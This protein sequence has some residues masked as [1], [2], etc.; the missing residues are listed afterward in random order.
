MLG[1]QPR[2]Q[3][4]V[5]TGKRFAVAIAFAQII[6]RQRL[7]Q[8]LRS[9]LHQLVR[10]LSKSNVRDRRI[11]LAFGRG[12][13]RRKLK[14]V[15]QQQRLIDF[16]QIVVFRRHP[17]NRDT[18]NARTLHLFRQR[19]HRRS[20][21][22]RQQRPAKQS[23]LLPGHHREGAFPQPPNIVQRLFRSSPAAILLL[24]HIGNLSVNLGPVRHDRSSAPQPAR[25]PA[26]CG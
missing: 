21:E 11:E 26:G 5:R 3:P 8:Q 22:Q 25:R 12:G 19:Q 15:V 4:G 20:L 17:E 23:D 7:A 2:E 24:Q 13:K 18:R 9:S 1:K 16:G 10:A 14:L 6:R